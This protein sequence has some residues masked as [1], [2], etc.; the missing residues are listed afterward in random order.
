[1]GHPVHVQIMS[2]SYPLSFADCVNRGCVL[3]GHGDVQDGDVAPDATAGVE[4]QDEVV[5]GLVLRGGRRDDG[6]HDEG[7]A[8]DDENAVELE[9]GRQAALAQQP[10]GEL[11]L[12]PHLGGLLLLLL[13][14]R[15][16]GCGQG[17]NQSESCRLNRI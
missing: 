4:G 5:D 3:R 12:Q 7:G 11:G 6:G 1:M 9:V 2:I 16:R 10:P 17:Q 8:A 14:R 15:G 13:L